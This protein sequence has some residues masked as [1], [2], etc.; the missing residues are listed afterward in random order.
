MLD[1]F[2]S[3]EGLAVLRDLKVEWVLFDTSKYPDFASVQKQ[4][5]ALGLRYA[6]TIAGE[7]VFK[8]KG[9]QSVDP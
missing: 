3:T 8:L 1:G 6:D 9:S 7:A 5:E 4:V 2:P